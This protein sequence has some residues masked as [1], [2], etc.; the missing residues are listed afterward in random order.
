MKQNVR[1]PNNA[2]GMAGALF[3]PEGFDKGNQYPAIACAHPAGGV[4]D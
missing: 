1:F 4:K 3:L 2:I